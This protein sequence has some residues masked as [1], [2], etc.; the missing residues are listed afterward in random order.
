M[1]LCLTLVP[2]HDDAHYSVACHGALK[3]ALTAL[4]PR[5]TI[6][7]PG[8]SNNRVSNGRHHLGM[9][10]VF[11][12]VD[13]ALGFRPFHLPCY[14]GGWLCGACCSALLVVAVLVACCSLMTM[15]LDRWAI[16]VQGSRNLLPAP[17]QSGKKHS[18]TAS[19][20]SSGLSWNCMWGVS[21][22]FICFLNYWI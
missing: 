14:L 15:S 1:I 3:D 17:G 20:A 21:C 22:S 5:T 9:R 10:I 18:S 19:E 7:N 6:A 13:P 2:A 4:D 16:T 8:A 12:Y 11:H